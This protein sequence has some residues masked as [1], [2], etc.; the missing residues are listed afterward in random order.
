MNNQITQSNFLI[1][2]EEISKLV[3]IQ[4]DFFE[5]Y[6]ID[7]LKKGLKNNEWLNNQILKH[8]PEK[9]K[10]DVEIITNEIINT[11]NENDKNLK[12][13]QEAKTKG[14]NKFEWFAKNL[15]S[16]INSETIK[17]LFSNNL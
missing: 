13:L 2:Q 10:E 17:K 6:K 4:N 1:S 8:L 16:F 15:S 7:V 5:S 14:I 9:S 11:I 12:S 3:E